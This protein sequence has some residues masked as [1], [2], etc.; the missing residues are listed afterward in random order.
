MK[1]GK[2][3]K[4]SVI[5]DMQPFANGSSIHVDVLDLADHRH[6]AVQAWSAVSWKKAKARRLA[7][8]KGKA[9]PGRGQTAPFYRV[10][11][12]PVKMQLA[13]T[14]CLFL[15][16]SVGVRMLLEKVSTLWV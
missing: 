2:L 16:I 7:A 4:T 1:H 13:T 12:R 15:L 11:A 8:L 6:A 9:Q 3:K 10:G 5:V 14:V